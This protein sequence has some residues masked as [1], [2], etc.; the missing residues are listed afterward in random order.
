MPKITTRK[1]PNVNLE[2]QTYE[3]YCNYLAGPLKDHYKPH[4]YFSNQSNKFHNI[5]RNINEDLKKDENYVDGTVFTA[6]SNYILEN[7]GR[8][9][10]RNKSKSR[11]SSYAESSDNN[12]IERSEP[13]NPCSSNQS[14]FN[15]ELSDIAIINSNSNYATMTSFSQI[16]QG[17]DCEQLVQRNSNTE[18]INHEQP[19]HT[20]T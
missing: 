20:R 13:N 6:I 18:L 5:L 15:L 3:I 4:Q 2:K 17:S 19:I 14:Q 7:K 10:D 11:R 16:Q 9:E 8:L 1:I 12:P